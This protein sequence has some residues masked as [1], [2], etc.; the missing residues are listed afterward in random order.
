VPR[1]AGV[2]DGVNVKLAK[3]G[4]IS[5]A[6][7]LI[8]TARA[9]GMKVLLGCMIESS[10]GI[11]AALAVAPLVDWI[12]LDGHL[13]IADDPFAGIPFA[14]GRLGV[15]DGPGLGVEW[16]REAAGVSAERRAAAAGGRPRPP[17][18]GGQRRRGSARHGQL[19]PRAA[20]PGR[21]GGTRCARRARF[22]RA[23]RG[24]LDR[25]ERV[26]DLREALAGF[27]RI[28]ATTAARDRPWPSRLLSPRELAGALAADHPASATALVFGPEPSGLTNAELA[29]A[30]LLVRVPTSP[31]QPS[32]N[33]AQAVLVVAYELFV[34]RR[35]EAADGAAGEGEPRASGEEIAGLFDQATELLERIRFARDTT[36]EGVERDLRRL[37]ARAAPTPREIAILR[38]IVRRLGHALERP[39]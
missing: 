8:A 17:A 24:I 25:A 38:G 1:L 4:G 11:A 33:L 34:A 3:C 23:R 26:A 31:V 20:D 28:V 7:R 6:L 18:G 15:P 36:I 39:S 22:R 21:A 37:L 16:R 10:F 12:D 2:Y 13:L 5:G 19:R 14:G 35:D 9:H 30:S 29:Q 27:E 32:L